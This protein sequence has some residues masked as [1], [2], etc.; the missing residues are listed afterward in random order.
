M[1]GVKGLI[2]P[3]THAMKRDIVI[4]EIADKWEGLTEKHGRPQG[5]ALVHRLK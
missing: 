1:L 5:W 4:D 3:L 2:P